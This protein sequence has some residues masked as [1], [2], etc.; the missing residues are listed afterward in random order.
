MDEP[1]KLAASATQTPCPEA[2]GVYAPLDECEQGVVAI[3]VSV[4]DVLGFA[5]S[6]GELYG[7]AYISNKPIHLAEVCGR[8]KMSKGS[9]SQGLRTLRDLGALKPVYVAGDRRD[10]FE[11][12]IKIRVLMHQLLSERLSPHID[13]STGVLEELKSALAAK[14]EL[15]TEV[16]KHRKERLALLG[17]WQKR[18]SAFLPLLSRLLR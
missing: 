13:R 9:A 7:L 11:P 16:K 14:S 4:A 1:V 18:V 12:E 6:L 5:R 10:Y 15:P 3:F 2:E 8:L 17:T